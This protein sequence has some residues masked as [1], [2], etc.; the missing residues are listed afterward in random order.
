VS[1][2]EPHPSTVE[3]NHTVWVAGLERAAQE[4]FKPML[5]S[6]LLV[7][8]EPMAEAGVDVTAMVGLAGRLCGLL[9][10]RCSWQTGAKMASKM[11]GVESDRAI[12]HLWDALGELCNMIAGNFKNKIPGLGDGCMLSVPTVITGG[13]YR[14]HSISG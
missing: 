10:V 4:V 3:D 14:C 8:S 11:L 5:G 7:V 1:L 13:D 2:I 6:S 9:T 12:P